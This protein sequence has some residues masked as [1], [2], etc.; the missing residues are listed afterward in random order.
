MHDQRRESALSDDELLDGCSED[1]ELLEHEDIE[2]V[3]N[4]MAEDTRVRFISVHIHSYNGLIG[5]TACEM[6]PSS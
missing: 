1:T 3:S 2:H 5:K 6:A 4:G